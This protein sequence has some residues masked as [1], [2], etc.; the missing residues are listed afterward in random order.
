MINVNVWLL[1][2]QNFSNYFIISLLTYFVTRKL[3]WRTIG[4]SVVTS[5]FFGFI[6]IFVGNAGI[7]L[8]VIFNIILAMLLQRKIWINI[9][10]TNVLILITILQMIS[11]IIS[12]FIFRVIFALINNDWNLN[13]NNIKYGGIIVLAIVL[14][15]ILSIIFAIIIKKDK[16]YFENWNLQLSQYNMHNQIFW[17]VSGLFVSLE[18]LL[19]VCDIEQ[20]TAVF[21]FALVII[22]TIFIILM[23][24]IIS[25]FTSAYVLKQETANEIKQ[26]QQ[27]E[28]YLK[29]IEKQYTDIRRFRHD[30]KNIVLSMSEMDSDKNDFK[31]YYDQLVEN[32]SIMDVQDSSIVEAKRILN[33]P[34]KGIIVQK[35]FEANSKDISLKLELDS[36]IQIKHNSLSIVRIVGIFIDNALEYAEKHDL[37]SITCAIVDYGDNLEISVANELVEDVNVSRLFKMGYSTKGE[38]RGVGLSNVK[39]I[40]DEDDNLYLDAEVK[41]NQ[42]IMTLG[43]LEDN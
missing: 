31:E 3:S 33:A 10:D 30:F 23:G 4:I 6:T 24:I 32:N 40:V 35:Y 26:N 1:L 21:L 15:Y 9:Q 11:N 41:N 27:L 28:I 18:I 2:V 16:S 37:N 29:S 19:I 43:I 7:I 36:D 39:R 22:F 17:L 5:A 25:Q 8:F 34:L 42:L 12:V 20:V 38:D 13:S 14:N